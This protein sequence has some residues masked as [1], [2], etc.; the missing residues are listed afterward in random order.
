MGTGCLSLSG[1]EDLYVILSS[2]RDENSERKWQS[3]QNILY[4]DIL[5][6][7]RS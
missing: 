6:R 1:S 3:D 4:I 2:S 5:E 7:G